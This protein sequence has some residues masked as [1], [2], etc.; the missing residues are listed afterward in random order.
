MIQFLPNDLL[1]HHILIDVKIQNLRLVNKF[2][3]E[4]YTYQYCLSLKPITKEECDIYSKTNCICYNIN[5]R[6]IFIHYNGFILKIDVTY[7]YEYH[8]M[9]IRQYQ[10]AFTSSSYGKYNNQRHDY[11]FDLMTHLSILNKRCDDKD[12]LK[13]LKKIH[14]NNITQEHYICIYS[15]N[16]LFIKTY[17]WLFI[18]YNILLNNHNLSHFYN[19]FNNLHIHDDNIKTYRLEAK[20]MYS[21]IKKWLN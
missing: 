7:H 17:I 18:N 8:Q 4:N 16:E 11:D 19:H 3:K 5:S 6:S 1:L 15:S 13:C 12:M 20:M 2:F 9:M 10:E 21:Q 14:N